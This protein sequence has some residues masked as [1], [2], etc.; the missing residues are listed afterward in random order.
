MGNKNIE[1]IVL[2]TNNT[3]IHL[4]YKTIVR[5]AIMREIFSTNRYYSTHTLIYIYIQYTQNIQQQKIN[6]DTNKNP[7]IVMEE[8]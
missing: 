8:W 3:T 6:I 7:S 2:S 5:L 1:R 4:N